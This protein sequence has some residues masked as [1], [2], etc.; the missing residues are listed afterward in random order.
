MEIICRIGG[1]SLYH[2]LSDCLYVPSVPHEGK[3]DRHT[4]DRLR[5]SFISGGIPGLLFGHRTAGLAAIT[6]T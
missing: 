2:P 4:L 1:R 6:A 5:V 3:D